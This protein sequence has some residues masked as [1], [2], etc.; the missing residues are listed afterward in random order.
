MQCFGQIMY[1]V[2]LITFPRFNSLVPYYC[3]DILDIRVINLIEITVAINL[4][5]QRKSNFH[6]HF[7]DEYSNTVS[8]VQLIYTAQA[9]FVIFPPRAFSQFQRRL[10]LLLGLG[11]VLCDRKASSEKYELIPQSVFYVCEA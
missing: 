4:K 7:A 8:N 2:L 11:N 5:Y 10:L 1:S 9:T 3:F 6:C